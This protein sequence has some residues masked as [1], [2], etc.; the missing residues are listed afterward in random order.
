MKWVTMNE[1]LQH[2]ERQAR[3]VGLILLA[4]YASL[5]LIIAITFA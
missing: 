5:F 3:V 2:R 4:V 1:L